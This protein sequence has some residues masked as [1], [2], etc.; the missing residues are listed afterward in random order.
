[1]THE[2]VR[3]ASHPQKWPYTGTFVGA[4]RVILVSSYYPPN[5]PPCFSGLLKIKKGGSQTVAR[6]NKLRDPQSLEL[7]T[8][9]GASTTLSGAS[10]AS[11]TLPRA[12]TTISRA[13]TALSR[14]STTL[15]RASTTLSRAS[16]KVSVRNGTL[17]GK[18][19]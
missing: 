17:S 4:K 18:K 11:T 2:C 7:S 6:N 8:L 15:S 19:Y 9:S 13:S 3:G 1:M 5:Y 14:A 10:R 16:G 12:S